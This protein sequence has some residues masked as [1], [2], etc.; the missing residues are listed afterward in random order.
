MTPLTSLSVDLD[1]L[2]AYQ[3]THGDPSWQSLPSFLD[4]VVPRIIELLRAHSLRITFFVVGQDAELEMNRAALK[5]V[6]NDGHEL[7]NHSFGHEP[8]LHLLGDAEIEAEL[9]RTED[10]IAAIGGGRT[11]GFRGPGYSLSPRMLLALARRGYRYD[12]STLPSIVGPLARAYYLKRADL[13]E[14]QREK[15]SRLF[16]SFRDGLRP[17]APYRWSIDG[18][19]LTELPVTTMPGLRLPIHAS[20]LIFLAQR[21]WR[22]ADLYFQAALSLCR[23]LSV[24]PS[25]LLHPLDFV[26]SDDIDCLSFFPGM[27]MPSTRKL[28]LLDGVLALLTKRFNVVSLLEHVTAIERRGSLRTVAVSTGRGPRAS[29]RSPSRGLSQFTGSRV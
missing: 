9:S 29:A 14:A 20:Y 6:V 19:T 22:A 28:E 17:I 11:V 27:T 8:W 26:G 5:L 7:G 4:V 1:N 3:R 2:W 23:R 10:A 21:N 12:A 18:H 25:I 16:G 24:E 15:R 13:T